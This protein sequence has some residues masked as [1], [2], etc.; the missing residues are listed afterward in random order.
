MSKKKIII[1]LAGLIGLVLIVMTATYWNRSRIGDSLGLEI[2]GSQQVA[3]GSPFDIK[4][5]V[6]NKSS[7]ILND[8]R[9][10]LELPEGIVFVGSPASKNV[11][12][13]ELGA[14]GQGSVIEESF[15]LLVTSGENTLKR[16][17]ASLSYLPSS[18]G[19][20]FEKEA[21]FDMSIGKPALRLDLI[22]PEKV[23][24]GEEFEIEVGYENTS[25]SEFSDLNL[26]LEYPPVFKYKSATLEPDAGTNVWRLGALHPG[27]DMKFKIS[28]VMIGPDN[29]FFDLRAFI[30]TEINGETYTV[31]ENF[32]NMSIS[33]SPLSLQIF[34]NESADYV[35]AKGDL[36]NYTL[37]YSN[38]TDVGLRDVIIKAKLT[39]AM[40][41]FGTIATEATY[42]SID[43][44]L[45]WDEA[46]TPGLRL[47]QPGD[48]GTV[49]FSIALRDSYPIRR[50]A[51]RNFTVKVDAEIESPTVPYYL[52][53]ER[54]LG[55]A[56]VEHKVRG[57]TEI[58]ALGFFRDAASGV[59]N[60]GPFP[61]Q[62][63]KP[64]QYTIHWKITNF[65]TDVSNVLVRAFLD[66]DT[67]FVKVVKSNIP[68]VPVYNP[69]TQ[70]ITWNISSIRATRGVLDT[71]VEAI[72]QVESTPS[73]NLVGKHAPLIQATN[74]S[75]TDE[76]TGLTL[77]SSA[78]SISTALPD[79][80]TVD[81]QTGL[82][83]P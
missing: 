22:V 77:T 69:R 15:R 1:S 78:P 34:L 29:S 9:L 45:L 75:A 61:P 30:E 25:N 12:I 47:V 43:N 6:T 62:A 40:F 73:T 17:T 3:L 71:P 79:D 80:P 58:K 37:S 26:R 39:G 82:V 63:N 2:K 59:V 65:S 4:V 51:D 18:I 60:A 7:S 52:A 70:E 66:G 67:R 20:R 57:E 42:R 56:S 19:S 14:V 8:S 48:S 44:T 41:N 46:N 21:D 31:S 81:Y 49:N 53:A 13:R 32:A 72:F 55:L 54:T 11:D 16:V 68:E 35:G 23:L 28:G 33:P 5:T 36:L 10:T 64:T 74:L 83:V 24:S 38:N 27:S 50:L 76:F